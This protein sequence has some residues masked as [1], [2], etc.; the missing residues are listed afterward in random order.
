[1]PAFK[2]VENR[3]NIDKKLNKLD[4]FVLDIVS[5]IE[6]YTN[7]VI[8]SGY[9]AIFFGRSRA[10]EDVD[11]F[12]EQL[13]YG[14]FEKLF[15][16]LKK[17][18]YEFNEDDPKR[19]FEDYLMQGTSINL[20]EDEFPL[21][22]MEIKIAEKYTQKDQLANSI[23]VTLNNKFRLNFSQIETQ[24]AYKKFIAKS[25]KDMMDARHL[26]I[27]FEGLSIEKINYYKEL[28]IKEFKK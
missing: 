26:E 6:K 17:K 21:L 18:G 25:E 20:W 15:Q 3:L 11:M 2:V 1:M 12:I 10:T 19:L 28:F 27:A 8:I 13:S 9:V 23:K 4:K 24:I 7:Y 22:R 16:D 14:S 5:V